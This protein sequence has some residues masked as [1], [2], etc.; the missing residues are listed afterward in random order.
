MA[1]LLFDIKMENEEVY[2]PAPPSTLREPAPWP[3]LPNRDKP[4]KSLTNAKITPLPLLPSATPTQIS[5]A[6]AAAKVHLP[7]PY[8]NKALEPSIN[9]PNIMEDM[10]LDNE[11]VFAQVY[12]SPSPYFEAFQEELDI[13]KWTTTDHHLAGLTLIE[14]DGQLILA[15]ILKSIPAALIGKWHSWCC[16]ATLIEVEG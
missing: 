7:N 16:R 4:L 5:P 3:P 13:Q 8:A 2:E 14:Q 11:E 10:K 12:L 6:A 15:N 1:Q 9:R